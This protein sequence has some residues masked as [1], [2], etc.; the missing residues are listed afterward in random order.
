M[1]LWELQT[2]Q[3]GKAQAAWLCQM[4]LQR[5]VLV[6]PDLCQKIQERAICACSLPELQNACLKKTM[7]YRLLPV[8][9]KSPH[10][11]HLVFTKEAMG[12]PLIDIL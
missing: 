9:H 8:A 11:W 1:F 4:V 7:S 10:Q 6:M 12:G 5:P 3:P 2:A